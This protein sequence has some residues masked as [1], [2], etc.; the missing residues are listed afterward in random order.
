VPSGFLAVESEVG[1]FL[2]NKTGGISLRIVLW[3]YVLCLTQ[4][5]NYVFGLEKSSKTEDS[6][7]WCTL[8]KRV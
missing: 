5:F 2:K 4:V 3:Y 7:G 1:K 6:P 8:A